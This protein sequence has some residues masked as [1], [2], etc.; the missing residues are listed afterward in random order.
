M[1]MQQVR[2]AGEGINRTLQI[3]QRRAIGRLGQDFWRRAIQRA[4]QTPLN[5]R[6]EQRTGQR[7]GDAIS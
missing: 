5:E 3:A 1:L 2:L 4:E 7:D 6:R